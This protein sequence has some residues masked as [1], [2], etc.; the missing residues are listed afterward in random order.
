MNIWIYIL[1]IIFLLPFFSPD[2]FPAGSLCLYAVLSALL[3]AFAMQTRTWLKDRKIIL[4]CVVWFAIVF[5]TSLFAQHPEAALTSAFYVALGVLAFIIMAG[6]HPKKKNSLALVLIAASSVVAL[7]AILQY[8]VF[9]D[10]LIPYITANRPA[11]TGSELVHILDIIDRR[12]VF[13]VFSSP[14]LLASYLA[15]IN[16]IVLGYLLSARSTRAFLSFSAA[17]M[18][19]CFGL[20]LTSSMTGLVSF[21]FGIIIF[22]LI[23]FIKDKRRRWHNNQILISFGVLAGTLF[24]LLCFNRSF[25]SICTDS[26]LASLKNRLIFWKAAIRIISASPLSFTG[27]GNFAYLYRTY[28]PFASAESTMVHNLMLQLWVET[29]LYGLLAF[30]WFLYALILN[31]V[32]TILPQDVENGRAYQKIGILCA[33]CVFIFHNMAGFSFFVPQTALI[34]WIVCA[35]SIDHSLFS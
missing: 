24:V 17:L 3:L 30:L 23:L 20:W 34:F 8:F 1:V 15:M 13:S 4:P 25:S 14:N 11:L 10:K 21:V 18:L 2:V 7:H 32:R 35:L 31:A 9:F 22:F 12:R 6:A 5:I 28:V 33:V 29:G 26:L 27:L 19:N 16:M